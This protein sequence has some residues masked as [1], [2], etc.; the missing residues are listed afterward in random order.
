MMPDIVDFPG[1]LII[2]DRTDPQLIANTRS[3]GM[4]IN[5][6]EQIISP[7][8]QR[9]EWTISIPIFKPHH[10][11]SLR[12]FLAMTQGRFNYVRIRVCDMYRMS[13]AEMGAPG[14]GSPVPHSDGA[15][16]SDDTGYVTATGTAIIPD[17]IPEGATSMT[18]D[19]GFAMIPGTLFSINDWLYVITAVS[20][21]EIPQGEGWVLESG[22]WDDGGMWMTGIPWDYVPPSPTSRTIEFMPPIRSIVSA[23]DEMNFDPVCLWRLASD[24][25][26]AANLRVGKYGIVTLNFTEPVGR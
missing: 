22:E 25:D 1:G 8:S 14:S 18:I 10:M 13:R 17:N 11:R 6:F 26:G 24:R 2:G 9:W 19:P 20:D 21:A 5:G 16:F 15:F 7:L 3:G 12:A 4:A 23:G